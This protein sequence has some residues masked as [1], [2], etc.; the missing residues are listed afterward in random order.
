MPLMRE[1]SNII[2]VVDSGMTPEEAGGDFSYAS[3]AIFQDDSKT[4][5]WRNPIQ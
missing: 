5:Q 3:G 2:E 4:N 1:P